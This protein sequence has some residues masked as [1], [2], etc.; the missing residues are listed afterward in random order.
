MGR[1]IGGSTKKRNVSRNV[2]SFRGRRKWKT[3]RLPNE[4]EGRIEE[5]KRGESEG[6]LAFLSTED[7]GLCELRRGGGGKVKGEGKK[8]EVHRDEEKSH[9]KGG[10]K[11]GR[12]RCCALDGEGVSSGSCYAPDRFRAAAGRV[13]SERSLLRRTRGPDREKSS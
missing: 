2:R 1:R 12:S 3:F 8:K 13:R 10:F 5:G 6:N 4:K 7:F 9:S 11:R